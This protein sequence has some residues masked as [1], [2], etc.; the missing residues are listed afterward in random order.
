M[1]PIQTTGFQSNYGLLADTDRKKKDVFVGQNVIRSSIKVRADRLCSGQAYNTHN[2][3][4]YKIIL[5]TMCAS[6]T[7]VGYIVVLSRGG[8]AKP[9][10]KHQ[11]CGQQASCLH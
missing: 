6:T 3:L 7:Y 4:C 2:K 9:P 10:I 1:V 8:L 11:E 5:T